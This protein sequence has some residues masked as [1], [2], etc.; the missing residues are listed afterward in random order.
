M[1]LPQ[2]L[3][4][5][6]YIGLIIHFQGPKWHDGNQCSKNPLCGHNPGAS[7]RDTRGNHRPPSFAGH[8]HRQRNACRCIS[9]IA[10]LRPNVVCSISRG[11]TA[12]TRCYPCHCRTACLPR[13]RL[14]AKAARVTLEHIHRRIVVPAILQG[15]RAPAVVRL[16]GR[17]SRESFQARKR[18]VSRR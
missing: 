14:Q 9:C 10:W 11:M 18:G 7:L 13:Q 5:D 4:R 8:Y 3:L 16:T 17:G 2:E 1:Y 6:S 15:I 12:G